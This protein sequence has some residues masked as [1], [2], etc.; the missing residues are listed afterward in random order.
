MNNGELHIGIDWGNRDTTGVSLLCG[1]CHHTIESY[2]SENI[3]CVP[4]QIQRNCPKC[5]ARFSRIVWR[6]E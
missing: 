5:G 6:M 2:A 1:N 4:V 3:F